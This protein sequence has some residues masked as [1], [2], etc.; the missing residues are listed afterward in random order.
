MNMFKGGGPRNVYMLASLLGNKGYQTCIMNYND[1]LGHAGG[2]KQSQ[3]FN[4][5]IQ[6]SYGFLNL[7]NKYSSMADNLNLLKTPVFLF[8]QHITKPLTIIRNERSDIY[9]STFWQSVVPGNIISSKMK[10]D[11]IFFTQADER[12]FGKGIIYQKFAER[13]YQSNI[14]KITQSMWLKNFLDKKYG[15]TN[16]Y[17]GLG[18]DH[19]VFKPRNVIKEKTIFT[20]ARPEQ[21]KGFDIFLKVCKV[22]SDMRKDFKILIAGDPNLI[23][24]KMKLLGLNFEYEALGWVYDDNQMSE[25]YSKSIFINTGIEEAI[26]MPPLEAM[27]CGSSVVM[28]RMPGAIEYTQD[29]KNCL[30]CEPGNV[31]EFATKIESLLDDEELRK[32]LS[33][34]GVLTASRYTWENTINRLIRVMEST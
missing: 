10:S 13:A 21:F 23:S 28:T 3:Q 26:P 15:G 25:L 27:S 14:T 11:H 5:R 31:N 2:D 24:A 18:I 30:L 22:L 7:L 9:I 20:I 34:N 6:R 16:E 4:V 32:E 17:I 12:T 33:S 19:D 8:N 1:V 29:E